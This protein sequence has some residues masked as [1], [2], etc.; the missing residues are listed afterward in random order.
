MDRDTFQFAM[1]CSSIRVGDVWLDVSKSPVTDLGKKSKA[2]RLSLFKDT[3]GAYS[4]GVIDSEAW[5]ANKTE[6]LQVVYKDGMLENEISLAEVR[7]N[8]SL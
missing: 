6:V 5:K 4:T 8:A 2:G 3:L 1:K 7:K